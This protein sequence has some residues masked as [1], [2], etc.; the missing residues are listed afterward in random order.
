MHLDGLDFPGYLFCGFRDLFSERFR[1]RKKREW[2]NKCSMFKIYGIGM[3]A[4]IPAVL[5]L[6]PLARME[7]W[8]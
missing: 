8:Q 2:A 1:H 7:H 3:L 6:V 4:T 5:F